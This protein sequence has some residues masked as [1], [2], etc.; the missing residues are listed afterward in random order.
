MARN[1]K[2][3]DWSTVTKQDRQDAIDAYFAAGGVVTKCPTM[4]AAQVTFLGG[5]VS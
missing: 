2:K 5:R 4:N 3:F 1:T